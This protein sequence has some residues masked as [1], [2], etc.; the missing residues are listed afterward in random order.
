MTLVP[1]AVKGDDS[2]Q[3]FQ[4]YLNGILDAY[5]RDY[6][7]ALRDRPNP[8]R[9]HDAVPI[10]SELFP[11]ALELFVDGWAYGYL[12]RTSGSGSAMKFFPWNI[13]NQRDEAE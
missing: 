8:H 1:L 5:R 13:F 3:G 4:S 11:Y 7:F 9:F 12:K 2:I 6:Q 10:A